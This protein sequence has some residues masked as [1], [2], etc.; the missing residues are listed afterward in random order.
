MRGYLNQPERTRTALI[1]G[2]YN[3]GDMARLDE[4]GFPL[5]TGR[6][7]RFSKIG[8]E[9]APHLKVEERLRE[10]MDM[11]LRWD[12][13]YLEDAT[14]SDITGLGVYANVIYKF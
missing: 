2:Y 7:S 5:I 10:I 8:G 11:E 14:G 13:N 4:E 3:T 9:M 12:Q 1:D 6:L